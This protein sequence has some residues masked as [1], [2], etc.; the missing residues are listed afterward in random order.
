M[1]G[2]KGLL[3]FGKA[4]SEPSHERVCWNPGQFAC[5]ENIGDL[6]S[7]ERFIVARWAMEDWSANLNTA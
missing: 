2:N 3:N 1:Q 6:S 5:S 7:K 4:V